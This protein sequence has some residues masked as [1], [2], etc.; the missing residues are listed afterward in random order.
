MSNRG[1]MDGNYGP[2]TAEAQH[3]YGQTEEYREGYR[4]GKR[5]G[6]EGT[7]NENAIH[8]ALRGERFLSGFITGKTVRAFGPHILLGRYTGSY[9]DPDLSPRWLS[10]AEWK[11]NQH[12]LKAWFYRR[13]YP[14]IIKRLIQ[15]VRKLRGWA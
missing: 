7:L 1:F 14:K 12:G 5:T 8:A 6:N 10:E 2:L 13:D 3:L 4:L 15:E 11:A 9:P